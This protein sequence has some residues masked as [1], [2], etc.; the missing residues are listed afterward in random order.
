MTKPYKVGEIIE[1]RHC[2]LRQSKNTGDL[3]GHIFSLFE[4]FS[5][6]LVRVIL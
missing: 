5:S 3:Q 6:Y 2:L 4:R 1:M